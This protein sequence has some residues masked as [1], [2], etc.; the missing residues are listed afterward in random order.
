MTIDSMRLR[1]RSEG[2][3]MWPYIHSEHLISMTIDTTKIFIHFEAGD[4]EVS[5]FMPPRKLF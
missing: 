4:Y 2:S 3:E 5:T 1:K